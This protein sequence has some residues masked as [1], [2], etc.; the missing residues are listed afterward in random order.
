MRFT[1]EFLMNNNPSKFKDNNKPVDS[2]RWYDAKSF[3][4]KLNNKLSTREEELNF[5]KK[6][7]PINS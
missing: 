5:V 1:R 4:E 3:C 7:F 6:F 2:I